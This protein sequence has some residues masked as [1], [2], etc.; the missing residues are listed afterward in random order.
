M[1]PIQLMSDSEKEI[2][3]YKRQGLLFTVPVPSVLRFRE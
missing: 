2:D 3:V 1:E